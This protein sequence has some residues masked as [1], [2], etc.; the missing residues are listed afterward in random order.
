RRFR[1]GDPLLADDFLQDYGDSRFGRFMLYLLVYR[2]KALDWD[3]HSHRIGFEG[4]EALA[5]FR[6][7]WHHIFPKKYLEGHNNNDLTDALANIAVIG[8][9]INI[10]ISAKAP[11]AYVKKYKISAGKLE[12]QFIDP[13]FRDAPVAEFENWVLQRAERLATEANAFLAEL[14]KGL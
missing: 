10:R 2:N 8:P 5:D 4:A 13:N 1:E 12:Q 14:R 7:Q 6:P 9:T 11:M 3:E